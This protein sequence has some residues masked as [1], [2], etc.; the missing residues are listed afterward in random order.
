MK[1][2]FEA[3][4][5]S[6]EIFVVEGMPFLTQNEAEKHCD[7]LKISYEEVKVVKKDGK[8]DEP[9][10]TEGSSSEDVTDYLKL[11]KVELQKALTKLEIEFNPKAK[12]DDLIELLKK[13]DL[14]AKVELD[15]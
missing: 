2:V 7:D 9:E 1:K 6:S 13:V 12:K 3:H 10:N 15:A 4:P 5:K 11:T 14:D 8:T